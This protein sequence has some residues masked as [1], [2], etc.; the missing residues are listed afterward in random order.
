MGE[1]LI[2]GGGGLKLH[3][4]EWGPRDA[5][6]IVLLHGWSQHH[7]CWSKQFDS[8]LA[9][10]F[11]I[12]APDLRGHGQSAAPLEPENYKTGSLWAEDVAAIISRLQLAA[13]II[14]GWSYGGFIIGD[15]LRR[16]GDG[17]IAGI[18]LVGGAIGIGP[19]WFGT[20][21]GPDFVEYAPRACS[22][23][24]PQALAAIQA[25]VH[26]FFA[27]PVAAADIEAAIGWSMLT[28]PAVR[29][30]M[31]DRDEDFRPDYSRLT[32][33]LL[34]SY[35]AADRILLPAMV[36]AIREA[37][38]TCRL[39]EYPG[40]GHAPFLEDPGRFNAELAAFAREASD[41]PT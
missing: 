11:R 18:N 38:P 3:V 36:E 8:P 26:R 23:D 28:Q 31:I 4:R 5:P 40:T 1:Q 25:L 7:L 9:D 29:A 30:A 12:I 32:K 39:S 6:A 22:L 34:A 35:G 16:Y 20:R 21:I 24:Q 15:Y 41:P 19:D 14:V 27:R 33:P 2:E 13:P 17:A 37:C 10:E